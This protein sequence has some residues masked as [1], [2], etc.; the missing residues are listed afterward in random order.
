M[1][2]KILLRLVSRER[3]RRKGKLHTTLSVFVVVLP[4]LPPYKTRSHTA[5][6]IYS[7]KQEAK[8]LSITGVLHTKNFHPFSPLQSIKKKEKNCRI[9]K[10]SIMEKA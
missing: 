1:I 10:Y 5:S 4:L 6:V 3:Q 2:E 9:G 8:R 7:R